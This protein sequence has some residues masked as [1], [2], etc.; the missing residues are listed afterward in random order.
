[1]VRQ[2][3]DFFHFFLVHIL[4]CLKGKSAATARQ[5][6]TSYFETK[7]F[8]NGRLVLNVRRAV[9]VVRFICSRR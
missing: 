7:R 3:F 2:I 8:L 4:L 5:S 6:A 9:D 1:M